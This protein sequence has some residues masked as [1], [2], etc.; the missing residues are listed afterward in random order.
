MLGVGSGDVSSA[1]GKCP[2]HQNC[3]QSV[4]DQGNTG[5]ALETAGIIVGGVGLAAVVGGLVWHFTEPTASG[6]AKGTAPGTQL[7]PVVA[8]GYAGLGL[9]GSF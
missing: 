8:P 7:T 3:D 2:T 4:A 5:R 9:G 6:T 1:N